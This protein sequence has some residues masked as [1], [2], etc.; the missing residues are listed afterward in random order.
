V[1]D[2]RDIGNTNGAKAEDICLACGLCC[3]G[4]IFADVKLQPQDD[5]DRLAASGL[6]LLNSKPQPG[7]SHGPS[8]GKVSAARSCEFHQPCAALQ[9][10]RCRVYEIRPKHCRDF[11]CLLLKRVKAGKTEKSAAL[12]VIRTARECSDRV[13]R[14]LRELGDVDEEL[15]LSKR[16]RRTTRRLEEIGLDD[17]TADLYGEL[18]LA[19]HDLNFLLSQSFY[20]GDN[21]GKR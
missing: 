9:G 13:W 2:T 4:T 16:F 17:Q 10:G 11:E 7:E 6:P 1:S 8:A 15:S 14:M 18:T 19:V 3:D 12:E 20:P 5:A 21:Q